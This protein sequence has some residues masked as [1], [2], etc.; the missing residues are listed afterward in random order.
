MIPP[1]DVIDAVARNPWTA[2]VLSADGQV[3]EVVPF[4]AEPTAQR[5]LSMA[6][7]IARGRRY[8]FVRQTQLSEAGLAALL[9]EMTTA[10]SNRRTVP[11]PGRAIHDFQP[12]LHPLSRIRAIAEVVSAWIANRLP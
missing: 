10:A 11:V 5:V 2:L 6:G 4:D 3:A 7:T 9:A 8:R 12:K 1:S